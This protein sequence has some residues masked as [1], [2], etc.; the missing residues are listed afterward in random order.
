MNNFQK[1]LASEFAEDY[2]EGRLSRRGG[3]QVDRPSHGS[4]LLAD[5]ILAACAPPPESPAAVALQ[6]RL[7][8]PP[9]RACSQRYS[10]PATPEEIQATIQ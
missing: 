3:T 6:V 7:P 5:P 4:L 10:E 2:E 8:Q 1:Y 9:P